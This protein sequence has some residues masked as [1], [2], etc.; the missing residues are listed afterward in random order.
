[1]CL[2]VRSFMIP[3]FPGWLSCHTWYGMIMFIEHLT[4]TWNFEMK[5]N[6]KKQLFLNSLKFCWSVRIFFF[7][8]CLH[9]YPC[10]LKLL[11]IYKSYYHSVY[12]CWHRSRSDFT[13]FWQHFL[14]K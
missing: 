9:P 13:L 2:L 1:M 6:I 4:V 7:N 12:M 8:I 11:T 14:L 5:K 3:F 10:L